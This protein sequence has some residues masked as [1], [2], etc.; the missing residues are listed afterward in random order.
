MREG[1][2]LGAA[3]RNWGGGRRGH[4]RGLSWVMGRGM[5]EQGG[6]GKL[7]LGRAVRDCDG[8]V[9]DN[10]S[11]VQMLRRKDQKRPLVQVPLEGRERQVRLWGA[12]LD[13]P[14]RVPRDDVPVKEPHSPR[15]EVS[16]RRRDG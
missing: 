9:C 4:S 11:D 7:I 8:S 10:N 15:R 1:R 2:A 13:Q 3:L 5:A 6:V 12:T 16:S 14:P